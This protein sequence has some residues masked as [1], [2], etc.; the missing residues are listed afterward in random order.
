MTH[1]D[2]R[3]ILQIEK[4]SYDFPWSEGIFRDCL[5][6]PHVCRVVE[7]DGAI[8][9]YGVMALGVD[10]CHLLNICVSERFRDR[11]IGRRIVEQLFGIARRLDIQTAFL[12]VR[13]SNQVAMQLYQQLGFN[14]VGLRRDYY[15]AK[16]G[17]EDAMVLARDLGD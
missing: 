13:V 15:P 8:V 9:G 2:I 5:N 3:Y 14:E 1:A 16:G 7:I 4:A 10:E 6:H 11:G 12:E 17:R